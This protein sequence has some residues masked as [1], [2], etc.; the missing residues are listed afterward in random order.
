MGSGTALH[1]VDKVM[2]LQKVHKYIGKYFRIKNTPTQ[3]YTFVV[4]IYRNNNGYT[5]DA[6]TQRTSTPDAPGMK[7]R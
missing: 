4:L 7:E 5:T 1:T 6:Q 3:K 2:P